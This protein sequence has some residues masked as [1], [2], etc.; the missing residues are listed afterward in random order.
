MY[1]SP[2]SCFVFGEFRLDGAERRLLRNETPISLP[3]KILDTLLLL[4]ENAGH[5]VE[6]DEFMKRLWPDTFVGEDALARNISILRKTL[7]ESSDS[8]SCIAT[9]PTRGYRFVAPVQVVS[10]SELRARGKQ[11]S[12]ETGVL[13]EAATAKEEPKLPSQQEQRTATIGSGVAVSH[14]PP[15]LRET[16]KLRSWPRRIAFAALVLGAGSVAG[17]ATFSLLSPAP[18]PRVTRL[19]RLTYSGNVDPWPRLVTDGTRVYFLARQGDHWNL[20]QTSVSGGEAQIIPTPFKNAVVLDVSPDRANLLMGSFEERNARMPI[21]IRPVQGGALKRVGDV[22]AYEALWHPNSREIVYAE[23]DGVYIAGADG[24]NVRKLTATDE[25]PTMLSWS[26]DGRAMRFVTTTTNWEVSADG[27]VLQRF[28]KGSGDARDYLICSWSPDGRYFFVGSFKNGRKDI[29]AVRKMRALFHP[30]SSAPVRLTNGPMSYEGMA[31]NTGGHKLFVVGMNDVGGVERYDP[32]TRQSAPFLPG[33]CFGPLEYSPDGEWVTCTEADGTILR[34]KPDGSEQLALVKPSLPRFPQKWSPDG[35][36][37]AFFDAAKNGRGAIFIVSRDGGTPKQVFP[38]DLNQG[39]PAWLPN[40]KSLAFARAENESSSSIWILNLATNQVSRL[41]RS[42]GMR[43]PAWSPDGR[44]IAADAEEDHK[45]MLF[46]VRTQ[47]WSQLAEGTLLNGIMSWSPD[48]KCL[49]FQ[50]ILGNNE[51][52]YRVCMSDRKPQL[53]VSFEPLLRGGV[54]RAAF[55]G[56]APDGSV[57]VSVERGGHD[58]YA[59]DLDLP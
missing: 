10:E 7:G 22:T 3:P 39:G 21:W 32:K 49:Y 1:Q 25:Q 8:Q 12:K 16:P 58:I 19:E 38:E 18:V 47:H 57:V 34:M 14:E 51:S 27:K 5:L 26:P 20:M 4:L 44:F 45:L 40:S 29:W 59:L 33:I 46:D 35:K 31:A 17:L 15:G 6:K 48:G 56:F 24:T 28:V 55:N 23:D 13:G 37:I 42:E 41:P 11:P 52:L 2:K 9:V 36:Q 54:H 43:N 50:D 30:S 53:A